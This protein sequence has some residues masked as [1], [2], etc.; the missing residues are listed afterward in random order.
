MNDA[1][2]QARLAELKAKPTESM[3]MDE[4][5]EYRQLMCTDARKPT[6]LAELKAK[7]T[8]SMTM[9]ELKEYAELMKAPESNGVKVILSLSRFNTA[10]VSDGIAIARERLQRTIS[11]Q[12]RMEEL[13]KIGTENM[14]TEELNLYTRLWKMSPFKRR[15]AGW[16]ESDAEFEARMKQKDAIHLS[17]AQSQSWKQLV[18]VPAPNTQ[19]PVSRVPSPVQAP[20]VNTN[21]KVPDKN[22]GLDWDDLDYYVGSVNDGLDEIEDARKRAFFEKDMD[23]LIRMDG[24]EEIAALPEKH[25]KVILKYA[26]EMRKEASKPE[27]AKPIVEAIGSVNGQWMPDYAKYESD[28]RDRD[29]DIYTAFNQGAQNA[30]LADKYDIDKSRVSRIVKTVGIWLGDTFEDVTLVDLRK[31]WTNPEADPGWKC[32][33]PGTDIIRVGGAGNPDIKVSLASKNDGRKKVI[34]YN[35]KTYF[36]KGNPRSIIIPV[37][38]ITDD[39][40]EMHAE[41]KAARDLKAIAPDTTIEVKVRVNE[42]VAGRIFPDEDVDWQDENHPPIKIPLRDLKKTR[43]SGKQVAFA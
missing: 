42:H 29:I 19:K 27:E 30:A 7:G 2:K 35:A 16:V 40:N 28:N 18:P 8:G 22:R 5:N 24:Y 43:V 23:A 26:A 14:T 31:Y 11:D 39:K 37:G 33:D 36:P 32:M 13:Q 3:T 41:I 38:K 17:P 4:V 15:E 1:E 12:S 34:F 25:I 21:K 6:R 10:P 20:I 9:V